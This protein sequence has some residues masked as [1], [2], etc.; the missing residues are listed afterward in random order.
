MKLYLYG[1]FCWNY[2]KYQEVLT[3]GFIPFSGLV[4]DFSEHYSR[5]HGRMLC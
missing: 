2:S 4:L 1:K 3:S 5:C